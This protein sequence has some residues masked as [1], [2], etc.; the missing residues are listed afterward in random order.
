MLPPNWSRS[1]QR[2]PPPRAP[3]QRRHR[4]IAARQ[5]G[6]TSVTRNDPDGRARYPAALSGP[7]EPH[8]SAATVAWGRDGPVPSPARCPRGS[9]A[10]PSRGGVPRKPA[11]GEGARRPR[12]EDGKIGPVEATKTR[13]EIGSHVVYQHAA[14]SRGHTG[15]P[16][17]VAL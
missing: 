2:L 16:R 13:H 10:C 15:G 14:A 11:P 12:H 7:L 9:P 8:G 1:T 5:A 6:S 4:P 3:R 17:D